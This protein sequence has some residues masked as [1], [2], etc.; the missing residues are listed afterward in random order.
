MLVEG[1]CIFCGKESDRVD[2]EENGFTG[3][4]CDC[5]L[6]YVS[7]RPGMKE[8]LSWYNSDEANT[9]GDRAWKWVFPGRIK[10]PWL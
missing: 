5:G 6:L 2:W 8:I 9:I 7:P 10:T 3:K 4:R 1:K